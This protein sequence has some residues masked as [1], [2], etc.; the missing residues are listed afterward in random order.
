MLTTLTTPYLIRPSAVHDEFI[1]D[2]K[3]AMDT[4]V[5]AKASASVTLGGTFCH[6]TDGFSIRPLHRG[7]EKA[8]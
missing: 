7:N 1:D 2:E 5:S 4:V 3:R 6:A 8:E